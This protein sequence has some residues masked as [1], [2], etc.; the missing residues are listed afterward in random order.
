[1]LCVEGC[2][3]G[4][5]YTIILLDFSD[6]LSIVPACRWI[7]LSKRLPQYESLDFKAWQ[8]NT[9]ICEDDETKQ[10]IIFDTSKF[11]L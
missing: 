6:P 9:L 2:F 11:P 1:M 7:D 4:S 8:G 10:P 3:W 5:P